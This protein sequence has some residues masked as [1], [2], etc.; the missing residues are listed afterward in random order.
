[1]VVIEGIGDLAASLTTLSFLPQVL[2]VWRTGQTRDI[3]LA[4][5]VVFVSG[6]V[7]WLVYG[8][9]IMKWPVIVGNAVTLLLAGSVLIMKL[10][11]D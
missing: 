8:I 10:R 3:S 7:M 4:M 11:N 5:Y 6:V 1:M 9:L 2:R